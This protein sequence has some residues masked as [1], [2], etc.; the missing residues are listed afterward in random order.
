MVSNAGPRSA[1]VRG[2]A[3]RAH[4]PRAAAQRTPRIHIR[5]IDSINHAPDTHS[6]VAARPHECITATRWKLGAKLQTL[7]KRCCGLRCRPAARVRPE[8][9]AVGAS[10]AGHAERERGRVRAALAHW[11]RR[12]GSRR[13]RPTRP[14]RGQHK[15]G[16]A[17]EPWGEPWGER[18]LHSAGVRVRHAVAPRSA[19]QPRGPRQKARQGHLRTRRRRARSAGST[20]ASRAWPAACA[21]LAQPRNG[22]QSDRLPR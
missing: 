3:E 5:V 18:D 20:A 21:G 17:G 14:A 4:T 19:P 13:H 1:V 2:G 6:Q 12:E 7:C 22:L 15:A 16:M 11:F 8:R 10:S 9:T